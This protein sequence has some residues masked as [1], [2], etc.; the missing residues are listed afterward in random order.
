MQASQ[1]A[2]IFHDWAF[3]EGLMPDGPFAPVGSSRAELALVQ[4]ITDLGKQLLRVKQVQGVAFSDTRSEIVVFTKRAAPQ[5]KKQLENLPFQIDDV[6]VRY[7][8]GVQ[9][10]TGTEP[11]QPFGGPAYVLRA[12]NQGK[13]FTCGSSISVGNNREAGTVLRPGFETPG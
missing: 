1:A 3:V 9:P 8:Q 7:R 12:V 13:F 4:P 5:R 11:T 6:G 2:R 10:A